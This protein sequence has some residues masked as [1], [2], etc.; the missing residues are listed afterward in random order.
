MKIAQSIIFGLFFLSIISCTQ[1]DILVSQIL[2]S[3]TSKELQVGESCYLTAICEPANATEKTVLWSSSSNSIAT[4]DDNGYV[5]AIAPGTAHIWAKTLKCSVSCTVS[6]SQRVQGVTMKERKVQTYIDEPITITASVFPENASNRAVVWST[7]DDSI[8]SLS[9]DDDNP[10]ECVVTPLDA[11]IATVKVATEDGSFEDSCV[12]TV[13]NLINLSELGTANCYIVP[14]AGRYIF[15]ASVKGNSTETLDGVVAAKIVWSAGPMESNQEA[16]DCI[17]S[18]S[19][20]YKDG[21][22]RFSATGLKGNV[23]VAAVND[24]DT[25]LWSWHLWLTDTPT[26][27]IYQNNAGVMM[28]RNLGALTTSPG[29]RDAGGC[30]YQWG[31]K[32]P[33]PPYDRKTFSSSKTNPTLPKAV[34]CAVIC[35]SA[36]NSQTFSIEHPS[37]YISS[38]NSETRYHW[39]A[40]DNS[41]IDNS[42]WGDSKTVYDPCP[43]G[44]KVPAGGVDGFWANAA[45]TSKGL[46]KDLWNH[47]Y[48]GTDLSSVFGTK[49]TC[50]Y[51]A[52]AI[53]VGR[54]YGYIFLNNVLLWSSTIDGKWFDIPYQFY[55]DGPSYENNPAQIYPVA[56]H[57]TSSFVYKGDALG[58]RCV[59]E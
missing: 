19:I 46:T 3:D 29:S 14:G 20:Q 57:E 10:F 6:V 41:R 21:T 24:V 40:E 13:S 4:V 27:N 33:F 23:V 37:T 48:S 58:V 2:I 38:A 18:D 54:S 45:N 16:E 52:N 12:V 49:E 53:I 42:L 44:Y 8:I 32:D 39:Y 30:F 47:S 15:N 5:K 56:S 59:R 43:P 17:I 36:D 11:G 1:E 34:S 9:S 35:E 28:D 55:V 31:R 26:D 25:I 22:I 51:P 50:W 7:N